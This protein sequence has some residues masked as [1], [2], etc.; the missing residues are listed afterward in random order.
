MTAPGYGLPTAATFG[1]REVFKVRGGLKWE[2]V[3]YG[4]EYRAVGRGRRAY[5][6]HDQRYHAHCVDPRE[7]ARDHHYRS[8]EVDL[9]EAHDEFRLL[10]LSGASVTCDDLRPTLPEE[11]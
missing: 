2:L 1:Y 3:L 8:P 4:Y 10:Y 7:P 6:F 11:P 9:F 5:H